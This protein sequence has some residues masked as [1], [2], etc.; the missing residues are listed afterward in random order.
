MTSR[1]R[2]LATMARLGVGASVAPLA[3]RLLEGPARADAK[4]E[5]HPARYW[6]GAAG[7][8]ACELCPRAETLAPDG[9]GLCR[10]R[11]NRGGAMVT[12]GYN[13][14]CILNIDPIEKNPLAHVL[15]GAESLSVA[16]AGCNLR[17]LYCQNWEFSQRRP[18]ETRNIGDFTQDGTLAKARARRLRAVAFTYTEPTSAIEFVS[19]MAG[20][21]REQGLRPTLCTCGFVQP[22]PLRELLPHFDAVTITYKGP[23]D[24]FYRKICQ[25]ELK[26]VLDSMLLVK[27]E[28]KWLEVATL[29]VPTLNDDAASLRSMA[30]WIARNLGPETPWHLER[31]VPQYRLKDL[32]ETPQAALEKARRIGQD[33]GLKFVYISNLAPHEGNHTYCP[34]CHKTVIKRLGFK[35][36]ENALAAGRCPHCKHPLPGLWT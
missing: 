23:T 26:P 5:P 10:V 21:A 33:A 9:W 12:H 2:F 18:T 25:A 8:V 4:G 28:K 32:P 13:Q 29:V 34:A 24:E 30:D 3:A 16:H 15:P 20:L 36:L 1:R 31:F 11:Q 14:P 19:E 22:R 17:C 6:H 27:A 35:V 7:D